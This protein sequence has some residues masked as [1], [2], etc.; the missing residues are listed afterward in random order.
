MADGMRQGQSR[1]V[2]RPCPPRRMHLS[3]ERRQ[4][5]RRRR[6]RHGWAWARVRTLQRQSHLSSSTAS[7]TRRPTVCSHP[8]RPRY[9]RGRSPRTAVTRPQLQPRPHPSTTS[10]TSTTSMIPIT[11]TTHPS[12]SSCWSPYSLV[13]PS[14]ACERSWYHRVSSDPSGATVSNCAAPVIPWSRGSMCLAKCT[15]QNKRAVQCSRRKVGADRGEGPRPPLIGIARCSLQFD[16]RSLPG[17][18]WPCLCAHCRPARSHRVLGNCR[19]VCL[20][21]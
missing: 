15:G 9:P 2:R 8:A 5:Q 13:A 1:D 10:T 12:L 16:P 17:A 14:R 4:P 3:C 20:C 18:C 21:E 7:T 6:R 11:L 19:P